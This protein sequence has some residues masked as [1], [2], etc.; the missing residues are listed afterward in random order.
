[1]NRGLVFSVTI[2]SLLPF[3]S[4]CS[5]AMT[6]SPCQP[7]GSESPT[8]T[9]GRDHRLSCS[10]TAGPTTRASRTARCPISPGSTGRRR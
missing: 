8:R 7:T 3:M 5:R 10:S 1:M 6:I 4:A 9:W 2:L